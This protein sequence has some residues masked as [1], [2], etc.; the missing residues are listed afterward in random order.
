MAKIIHRTFAS[1]YYADEWLSRVSEKWNLTTMFCHICK[2][3]GDST[4]IF[5]DERLDRDPS[6]LL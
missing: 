6:D 1:P 2:G 5:Y 3:W 4:T